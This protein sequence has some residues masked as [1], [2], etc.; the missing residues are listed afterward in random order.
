MVAIAK[1][2]TVTAY[3]PRFSIPGMT[4]PAESATIRSA[5]TA[6]GGA[7]A[8]PAGVNVRHQPP[9][10]TSQADRTCS[11][12]CRWRGESSSRCPSRRSR[13]SCSRRRRL[14][15]GVHPTDWPDQVRANA[16]CPTYED[17]TQ[18]IYAA[19]PSER[20]HDRDDLVA[21]ADGPD[22]SDGVADLHC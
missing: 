12:R 19:V 20:A 3:S 11:G 2:G 8:G 21:E 5:V 22:D 1:G 15:R 17:L 4:G 18:E 6:L 14:R 13:H 10:Q 7:T 9:D 16:G